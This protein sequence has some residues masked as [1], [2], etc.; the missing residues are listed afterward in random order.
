VKAIKKMVIVQVLEDAN[1]TES[2]IVLQG[3]QDRNP[4]ATVVSVGAQCDCGLVPGNRVVLDWSR[5]NQ[6]QNQTKT[7]Y[8]TDQSHVLAVFDE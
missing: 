2:G 5:V 6:F 4:V 8:V 1:T 7:Y 3:R